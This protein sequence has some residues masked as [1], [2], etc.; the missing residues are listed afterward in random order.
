MQPSNRGRHTGTLI[1]ESCDCTLTNFRQR[2]LRDGHEKLGERAAQRPV[3]VVR[4]GDRD[5]AAAHRRSEDVD[6]RFGGG[7]RGK[8]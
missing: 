1:G 7:V 2:S 6:G 8:L 5:Q 3:V 4:R